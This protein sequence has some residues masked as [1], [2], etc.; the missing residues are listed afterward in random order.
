MKNFFKKLIIPAK[1]IAM[2]AGAAALSAVVDQVTENPIGLMTNPKAHAKQL[3]M[4]ALL[5]GLAYLKQSAITA[6]K[7]ETK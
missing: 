4:T 7:K 6:A 2:G 1:T 3:G 5:V